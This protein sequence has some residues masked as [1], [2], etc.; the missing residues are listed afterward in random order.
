MG[1]S[2][3]DLKEPDMTEQLTLTF[4]TLILHRYSLLDSRGNL[5]GSMIYTE[6]LK[7]LTANSLAVQ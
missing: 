4:S 2:P 5:D 3:W 7:Y 6:D 1:Y